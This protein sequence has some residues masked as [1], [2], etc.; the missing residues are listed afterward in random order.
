MDLKYHV[1]CVMQS[2][3]FS[4][5]NT[6]RLPYSSMFWCICTTF[7]LPKNQSNHSFLRLPSHSCLFLHKHQQMLHFMSTKYVEICT[8]KMNR[9]LLFVSTTIC[10]RLDSYMTVVLLI[11]HLDLSQDSF[12]TWTLLHHC[13]GANFVF[14]QESRGIRQDR[15]KFLRLRIKKFNF[16]PESRASYRNCVRLRKEEEIMPSQGG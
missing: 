13:K 5:A 7:T 15:V 14:Y 1:P 11:A 16:R 8:R 12:S 3:S 4:E 9:T 2:S 10:A 6:S